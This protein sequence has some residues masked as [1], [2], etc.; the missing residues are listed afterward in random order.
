VKDLSTEPRRLAGSRRPLPR[1]VQS[2]AAAAAV[3]LLWLATSP[4]T[5]ASLERGRHSHRYLIASTL[6]RRLAGTPLRRLGF[7]FEAEGHRWN[8]NPFLVAAIT[9]TESSLGEAA[10]GY[11]PFGWNSCHGDGFTSFADAVRV[12]T[13]SLRV[14]YMNRWG[15][16]TVEAIGAI[17]CE[18]GPGWAER[19][20][21]FMR[22]LG[23]HTG[24]VV[25]P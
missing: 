1:S 2:A 22:E 8:V 16:R 3:V 15:L 17:Y 23:D 12:V 14:D 19:T 4:G 7:V 18:C 11:N 24:S 10:C 20:R 13:R 5:S 6:S 21:M 25:Y 9:G